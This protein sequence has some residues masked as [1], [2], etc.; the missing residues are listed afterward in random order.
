[1]HQSHAHKV[2]RDFIKCFILMFCPLSLMFVKSSLLSQQ[3]EFATTNNGIWF[4]TFSLLFLLVLA[5]IFV[6]VFTL[7]KV[8]LNHE[9]NWFHLKLLHIFDSTSMIE[10][11]YTRWPSQKNI[12]NE[13]KYV[14]NIIIYNAI[15][16]CDF[17]YIHT[18][19]IYIYIHI[20]YY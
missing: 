12:I 19:N 5:P 7:I 13:S 3:L 20:Y 2:Q 4:I 6:L 11:I 8:L 9:F 18:I 14:Y 16:I 17:C 15:N 10:I 1:M